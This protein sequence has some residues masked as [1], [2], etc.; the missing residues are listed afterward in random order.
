MV[1]KTQKHTQIATLLIDYHEKNRDGMPKVVCP[2]G[3]PDMV[4]EV[5]EQTSYGVSKQNMERGWG[6]R[7]RN[8]CRR[9][10]SALRKDPRFSECRVRADRPLVAFTYLGEDDLN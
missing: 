7:H 10:I 8:G 4:H 5:L 3:D 1:E 2:Y 9:I 6:T